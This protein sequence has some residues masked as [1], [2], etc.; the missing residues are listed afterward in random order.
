MLTEEDFELFVRTPFVVLAAEITEENIDKFAKLLGE[1]RTRNGE[2]YIAL[3][4]R[5]VPSVTRAYVG[6]HV[7]VLNGNVR[8][9]APKVFKEQFEAVPESK[10]FTFSVDNVEMDLPFLKDEG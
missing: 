8:C 3:D 9:Y 7:T 4:R 6:W 1:V 2:K 5:V 10:I